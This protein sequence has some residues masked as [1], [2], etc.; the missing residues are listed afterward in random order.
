MRT[1]PLVADLLS[2]GSGGFGA[3]AKEGQDRFTQDLFLERFVQ[4]RCGTDINGPDVN[5][6]AVGARDEDHGRG[7]EVS[8]APQRI[9]ELET[10]RP[11]QDHVDDR[12]V[13]LNHIRQGVGLRARRGGVDIRDVTQ[14]RSHQSGNIAIVVDDDDARPA[15]RGRIPPRV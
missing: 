15:R 9:D 4:D 3:G 6:R 8:V 1:D 11:R 13:G 12:Q 7:G 2:T 14:P 5:I 10:V